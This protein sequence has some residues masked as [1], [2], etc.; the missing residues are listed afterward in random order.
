MKRQANLVNEKCQTDLELSGKST[1]DLQKRPR[2]STI[3]LQET[4]IKKP[5]KRPKPSRQSEEWVEVPARKDHRK[6]KTK[7]EIK[8]LERPRRPAQ[9]HC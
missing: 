2:D 6:K 8:E 3:S 4:S 9:R 1:P 7:P 5:E